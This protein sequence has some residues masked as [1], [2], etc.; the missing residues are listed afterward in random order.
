MFF[1]K[2]NGVSPAIN[3]KVAERSSKW[4]SIRKAHLKLEPDC[5]ACGK[6]KWYRKLINLIGGLECHHIIPFHICVLICRPDLELDHR[7]LITLC[8]L[9]KYEHHILIG[10]LGDYGSF[11]TNVRH[12]AEDR[13]HKMTKKQILVNQFWKVSST[14]KPV[15][16]SKMSQQEKDALIIFVNEHF[17]KQ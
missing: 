7:N 11:N 13:F 2:D 17:P 6:S 4:H 12:D 14:S 8:S 1:K 5:V 15:D 9:Y 16:W 3:N 10:H